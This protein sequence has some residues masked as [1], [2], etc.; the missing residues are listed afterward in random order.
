MKEDLASLPETRSQDA[1]GQPDETFPLLH[2][3]ALERLLQIV[4]AARSGVFLDQLQA[5]LAA[6]LADLAVAIKVQ[7]LAELQRATHT[8]SAL[9]GT[10]ASPRL[11]AAARAANV[12]AL[13][14]N[15]AAFG[16]P[17]AS[18]LRLTAQLSAE[19][20]AFRMGKG[21]WSEGRKG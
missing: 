10:V 18:V 4:G 8:L 20:V 16:T 1:I 14:E 19:I 21:I 9:A 7:G 2:G 5:D 3:D 11:E 12:L 6:A 17:A 15:V 13:G